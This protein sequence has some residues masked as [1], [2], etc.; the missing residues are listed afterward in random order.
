MVER[1]PGKS[2]FGLLERQDTALGDYHSVLRSSIPRV[3][4]RYPA[5]ISSSWDPTLQRA[6]AHS[7]ILC[8]TS[9]ALLWKTKDL[10]RRRKK[11][12]TSSVLLHCCS[13]TIYRASLTEELT[14]SCSTSPVTHPEKQAAETEDND[15]VKGYKTPGSRRGVGGLRSRDS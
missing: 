2:R 1:R 3:Y 14:P 13:Q 6:T 5:G 10:Y 12:V 8:S 4:Q 15:C 11:N 9:Q 7:W